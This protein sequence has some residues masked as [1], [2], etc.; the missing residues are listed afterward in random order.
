MDVG[1]KEGD[2][3]NEGIPG[4][5]GRPVQCSVPNS[6]HR[7][8]DFRPHTGIETLGDDGQVSPDLLS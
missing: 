1:G 8:I 6:L 4:W 2:I 5:V 7:G 3:P